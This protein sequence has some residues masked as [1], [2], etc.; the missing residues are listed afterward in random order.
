M[1]GELKAG[2]NTSILTKIGAGMICGAI[3]ITT[4]NPLEV[5]KVRL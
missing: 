4:A 3:G 1:G 5:A 2:E